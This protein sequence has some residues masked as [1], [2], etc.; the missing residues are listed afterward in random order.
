MTMKTILKAFVICLTLWS[1]NLEGNDRILIVVTNVEEMTNGKPT[2]YWLSEVSHAWVR[3][4]DA[5]IAVE[6]AS[7]Q[8]G[9]APMDPRSFNLADPDNRRFWEDLDAVQAL[10]RTHRLADV[11]PARFRGI[12]FAGGHGTM[13]DFPH[14]PG[15]ERVTGAIWERGGI[16]AAVCHGPAA[17]IGLHLPNGQP[18]AAHRRVTGFTNA[19]EDA[20]ALTPVVP[21]LLEDSLQRDGGRFEGAADF[22]ANVVTDGRLITGQNPASASG[23][24]EAMIA[25]LRATAAPPATP[26]VGQTEI[27]ARLSVTP[28][29]VTV[30]ADGRMFASIHGARRDA[31]AQ[32]IEIFPG[33][34]RYAPF[35]DAS[36]NRSPGSGPDVFNTPH[37]VLIDE[38]NWLWVIDHG[39]WM[40]AGRAPAAPRLFAFDLA[41]GSLQFRHHFDPAMFPAGQILQDLAVDERRGFVYLADSGAAPGI[42]VVDVRAHHAWKYAGH[43]AFEA[44]SN[45][46]LTVEGE[47]LGF[48]QPDGRFTA[49]RV[50]I[51]PITLSADGETLFWGAMVGYSI[52]AAPAAMLREA[53]PLDALAPAIVTAAR[54]PVSDGFSTDAEGNHFVTNLPANGIDRI[55]PDGR[56]EPLVR[57]ARFIWPDNVRFG[58]RSWLYVA[59]NQLNRA[60]LFT[61][62][63]DASEAPYLIARV[64]TGTAGR[65][66]K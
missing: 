58:P 38:R 49:A 9:F 61:G 59:V 22:T 31:E 37:G 23:S 32:L 40:P 55:A 41:D 10:A 39:N 2:G 30:S 17:L 11:N 53:R 63:A 47:E 51:N 52:Y 44:E 50:P 21:F 7:P 35:P 48:P 62:G 28:G 14:A 18:I 5:G 16:V 66:G 57:D 46:Q 20:V 8:G 4:Q 65:P 64:W 29:N 15:V 27:V 6:F 34:D 1:S 33:E 56:V 25:L 43:P 3:F 12:Y 54:K 45:A 36:W 13:W 24:A 42:V 60:S 19:E 26:A